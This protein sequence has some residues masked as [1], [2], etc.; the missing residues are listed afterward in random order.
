[1]PA[2]TFRMRQLSHCTGRKFAQSE[3]GRSPP[4]ARRTEGGQHFRALP[5]TSGNHPVRTGSSN[6]LVAEAAA[7]R[8]V[9][10]VPA[11]VAIARAEITATGIGRLSVVGVVIRRPLV[12]G[13]RRRETARRH[14]RRSRCD[15]DGPSCARRNTG[16]DSSDTRPAPAA[17]E[18]NWLRRRHEHRGA[19]AIADRAACLR[20]G[21]GHQAEAGHHDHGDNDSHQDLHRGTPL[22]TCRVATPGLAEAVRLTGSRLLEPSIAKV[23]PVEFTEE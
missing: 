2:S 9:P 1:M 10:A 17:S 14:T 16:R 12:V 23:K 22:G 5:L 15:H 3:R 19:A 21:C 20:L 4:D 18:R 13:P 6:V 7:E 8:I 11:P